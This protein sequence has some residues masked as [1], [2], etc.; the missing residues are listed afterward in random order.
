MLSEPHY[1]SK[2]VA[3]ADLSPGF[4]FSNTTAW[5]NLMLP[6]QA[7][8][9]WGFS[10]GK[11]GKYG[12]QTSKRHGN[13]LLKSRPEHGDRR[14]VLRMVARCPCVAEGSDGWHVRE[15]FWWSPDCWQVFHSTGL[16][17]S[18]VT[19]NSQIDA[20]APNWELS[21]YVLESMCTGDTP[22]DAWCILE[23]HYVTYFIVVPYSGFGW[24]SAGHAWQF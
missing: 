9:D 5:T 3:V 24:A 4:N 7:T 1:T 6:A 13:V 20:C 16:K 18:T 8:R 15:H 12:V 11:R 19:F 2:T 23:L 10:V 14:S 21:V 17:P 22:P